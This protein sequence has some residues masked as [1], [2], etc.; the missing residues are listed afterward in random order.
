M[1]CPLS[2]QEFQDLLDGAETTLTYKA[3]VIWKN[4]AEVELATLAWVN[5]YNN[6]KVFKRIS[7]IL[8]VEAEKNVLCFGRE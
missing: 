3:E 6:R 8:P 5:W 2:S 4:H 7:H 1:W